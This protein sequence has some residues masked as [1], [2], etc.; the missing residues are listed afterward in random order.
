MLGIRKDVAVSINKESINKRS[1]MYLS[2]F[3]H[4]PNKLHLLVAAYM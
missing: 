3:R 4:S 1:S 2:G